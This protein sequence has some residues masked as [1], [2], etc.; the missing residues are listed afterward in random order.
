MSRNEE[1]GNPRG[2][3]KAACG[4]PIEAPQAE[5]SSE[6]KIKNEGA[7]A[8]YS[9]SDLE[10]LLLDIRRLDEDNYISASH[11]AAVKD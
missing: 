9:D 4:A 2:G 5:S 10:R 3:G 8:R 11:S 7:F 1:V 6:L